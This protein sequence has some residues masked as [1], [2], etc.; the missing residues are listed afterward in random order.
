MYIIIY[1]HI[2]LVDLVYTINFALT[3]IAVIETYSHVYTCTTHLY[4]TV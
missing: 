2:Y 1:I 4:Q 3:I